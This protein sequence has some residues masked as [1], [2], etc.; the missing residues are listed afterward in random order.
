MWTS[1]IQKRATGEHSSPALPRHRIPERGIAAL[2]A[3][4]VIGTVSVAAHASWIPAKLS[5]RTLNVT[6]EAHLH[7][8]HSSGSLLQEEGNATG[9]L[10]GTVRVSFRVATSVSGSFTIYPRGGGSISGA[11]SARLHSNGSYAS[12]GGSISVSHGT[13]RY[14]HAHGTGGFYGTVDRRNNALLIQ[15]TGRLSY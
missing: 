15:T 2:A 3:L 5:G 14:A 13:G 12:F 9:A 10:P 1:L 4:G 8:T 11:G 7:V 6:D